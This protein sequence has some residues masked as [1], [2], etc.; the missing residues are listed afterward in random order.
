MIVKHI[1]EV[2]TLAD[3]PSASARAGDIYKV[4]DLQ[5]RF[6]YFEQDNLWVRIESSDPNVLVCNFENDCEYTNSL[7]RFCNHWRDG[8]G[9]TLGYQFYTS[10]PAGIAHVPEWRKPCEGYELNSLVAN[11]NN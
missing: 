7:C 4:K 6:A 10:V 9:C 11:N 5:M 8:L 2:D 1:P 3:L